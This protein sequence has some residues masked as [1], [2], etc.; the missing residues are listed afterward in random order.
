MKFP[1][2][3]LLAPA[4]LA[5][6]L[7]A[8]VAAQG[9]G[10]A[11]CDG[12]DL[13]D[14]LDPETQEN[15]RREAAAMPHP[16]GLLWQA[17]RGDTVIDIFGT[18]HF[19]HRLTDAHLDRLAPMIAAAD[20][21]YLEVSSE[22]QTAMQRAMAENP[23]LMFITEGPTLPDL[24][25]EED[26]Q[27]YRE[28]MQA[29]MIPGFMAAKFKPLWAGMMLGIGPCEAQSGAFEA[30]GIDMLVGERARDAGTPS[31]SLEDFEDLLTLLDSFP[32]DDQIE[33]IRMSLA[34]PGDMN[35]LSYTIRERYLSEEI[36]LT[37][38]FSRYVSEEFGGDAGADGFAMVED[39]LLEKRNQGWIERLDAQ[40]TPGDHVLI[41]VGA[42]HLPGDAG[43]LRLLEQA[44]YTVSRVPL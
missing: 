30:K 6:T 35:D 31:R 3:A 18:Y 37:L 39:L 23:S 24:L 15:L 25:G 29:R 26:W 1:W 2:S 8:P 38:A 22:D 27:H 28:E 17:T 41:A 43:I 16:E 32:M 12:V 13:I 9:T 44:G 33:M 4:I 11:T 42:G 7:A 34:W 36:A 20:K 21:I 10:G 14:T 19:R 5:V 40:V